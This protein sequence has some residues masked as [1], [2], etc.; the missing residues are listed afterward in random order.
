MNNSPQTG[1]SLTCP[2]RKSNRERADDAVRPESE[3]TRYCRPFAGVGTVVP[4]CTTISECGSDCS[5]KRNSSGRGASPS[6]RTPPGGRGIPDEL[7]R[8]VA[9]HDRFATAS[10]ARSD[11][12]GF[13]ALECV[14]C[15]QDRMNRRGPGSDAPWCFVP[16]ESFSYLTGDPFSGRV[17]G[18]RNPDHLPAQVAENHQTI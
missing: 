15:T 5:T 2:Y 7:S 13:P 17:G 8:S 16:R 4:L 14:G 10:V 12:H 11:G 9:Q 3:S 1:S 18:H 6:L